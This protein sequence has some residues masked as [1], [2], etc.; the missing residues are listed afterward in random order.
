MKAA[1]NNHDLQ[2]RRERLIS[3]ASKNKKERSKYLDIV[4]L[5]ERVH[6]GNPGRE[7]DAPRPPL[8]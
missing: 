2:E 4:S 3:R 6:L 7:L 8:F 5:A 1:T